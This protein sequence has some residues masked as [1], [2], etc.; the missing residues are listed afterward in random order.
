MT[1]GGMSSTTTT[2]FRFNVDGIADELKALLRWVRFDLEQT[3]RGKLRK[4]PKI[5]GTDWNASPQNKKHCR[6]FEVAVADALARDQYVGFLFDRDL[7]YVFIDKDH[8]LGGNGVMSPGAARVVDT[9]RGLTE[10]SAGGTGLHIVCR[11]ALPELIEIA[12]DLKPIEVYPRRGPRFCVF[13]GDLLPVEGNLE[14]EIPDRAAELA[15]LFPARQSRSTTGTTNG[16]D[17]LRGELTDDEADAIVQW[18]EPFWTDGRR[19]HMGL[20]LSGELARQRVSREQAAAIIERC[21][22]DDSDPGAKIT[23][24]HD[25]FDSLGAGEDISGWHG[26]KD[27]CG[28]SDEDLAPLSAILDGFWRRHQP[29][30]IRVV[31]RV[32]GWRPIVDLSGEEARH[33]S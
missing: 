8:A 3:A 33:A 16:V 22:A 24:C 30:L 2:R 1:R 31:P 19:H 23:A 4:T 11:G 10:R 14:R 18:A 9:I 26:L 21:A 5:P 27:V 7:P 25:T 29:R 17:G 12:P 6:P 20:Y 15:A 28:L 13:T 32:R